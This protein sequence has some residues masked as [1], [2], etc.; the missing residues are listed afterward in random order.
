[1]KKITFY[2]TFLCT[3]LC[4]A[5]SVPTSVAPTPQARDAA[6]VIS[7]F[8]GAYTD[9]AGTNFNPN[10]GQS[11]FGSANTTFDVQG[12]GDIALAYPNFNYQGN[13]FGDTN[14][15]AMEFIHIDIWTNNTSVNFFLIGQG[16]GN[17]R[18]VNIPANPGQ[19][20]SLDIPLDDYYN[21]GLSGTVVRQFKYDGGDGTAASEIYVDNLYFWKT[22]ADPADDATLSALE[23]DSQPV[24]NFSGAGF[25]Y[26]LDYQQGTTAVPQ[27]TLATTTNTG[28][29]R[30]INQA[31]SIPGVATVVVT[32]ANGNVTETY[33]VNYTAT[34]PA[35]SPNIGTPDNEALLIYADNTSITNSIAWEYEFG[36]F[37]GRPDLLS[38]P[39]VDAATQMDFSIAGYGEGVQPNA[40]IDVNAYNWLHF[41]Y[42]ADSNSNEL[43][44]I[45]IDNTSGE[46]F[47][48]L[49]ID[50]N[51][52]TADGTLVQGSWQSVD[53]PLSTFENKGFNKSNLFQYKL[54]TTSDLVSEIVYFD[55]IYFSVNQ[56]VTLSSETV[57]VASFSVFP[58]PTNNGIWNIEAGDATI[59][60]VNVYDITGKQVLN[61]KGGSSSLEIN[62]TALNSGVYLAKIN[63]GNT[64]KTVKLIRL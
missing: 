37:A 12:S 8:S 19:W 29:T 18:S 54:G 15:A 34:V 39:N 60:N 5:Q 52:G 20:T 21:Q 48:E 53:V 63:A 6:D 40:P 32:S 23:V 17:E 59:S 11:G 24:P 57:D 62:G 47:Y 1:M 38:G 45:L 4:F 14:V 42:F 61:I 13:D 16:G 36:S 3:A 2:V 43:R 50:P 31:T 10:W 41:D 56:P 46:I 55:N 7:I 35:A 9:L 27:I 51:V 49:N 30:T 44:M 33:T 22:P 28:A 64:V 25:D 26:T 58:N